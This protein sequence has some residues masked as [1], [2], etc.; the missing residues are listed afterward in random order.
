MTFLSFQVE[1]QTSFMWQAQLR[2][3]WQHGN[4][5]IDLK[6]CDHRAKFE[7]EYLGNIS[8]L[9]VTPVTERCYRILATALHLSMGGAT[10]GQAGTGKT[11]TT[12]DLSR[13]LGQQCY[14]LNCSDQMDYKVMAKMFGGG[15][16]TGCWLCLDEFNRIDPEVLSVVATQLKALFTAVLLCSLPA[17]REAQLG[18]LDP[19]APARIAGTF[20]LDGTEIS[21]VPTVGVFITMNPGYAGRSELPE[22]VKV[23]FRPCA[24]TVPDLALVCQNAMIS[25]GFGTARLLSTKYFTLHHLAKDLLSK[26]DHY[27]FGMR[28][29]LSTIRASGVLKRKFPDIDESHIIISCVREMTL[30]KLTAPDR[31][32]YRRLITDVFAQDP[33]VLVDGS[34]AT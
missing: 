16:Q 27:D 6:I 32:I 22:N 1:S 18:C 7:Y 14:V 4:Q 11:E 26:Q 28:S 20:N 9:V 3:Y 13:E 29:V 31:A 21:L 12:K 8:R 15:A 17:N 2:R 33:T 19:G 25:E 10:F 24:M 23:L 5:D 34:G 30:S